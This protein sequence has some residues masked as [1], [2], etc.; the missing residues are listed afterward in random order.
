VQQRYAECTK[1]QS[2][3]E[4]F[5]DNK[6][7]EERRE[8]EKTQHVKK[9]N[10]ELAKRRITNKTDSWR[11]RKEGKKAKL[12]RFRNSLCNSFYYNEKLPQ[13]CFVY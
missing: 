13:K 1:Q 8:E 3:D 4:I 6:N 7:R 5:T 2:V 9:E 11:K 10:Q 12:S